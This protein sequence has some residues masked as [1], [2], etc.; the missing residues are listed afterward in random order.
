MFFLFHFNL[1]SFLSL[2]V[3]CQF[4]AGER[5]PLG[6]VCTWQFVQEFLDCKIAA[7]KKCRQ[8]AALRSPSVGRHQQW[9]AAR[10]LGLSPAG[11]AAQS[12]LSCRWPAYRRRIGRDPSRSWGP[13]RLASVIQG[14]LSGAGDHTG[15]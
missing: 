1:T 11:P 3:K 8:A 13:W 14:K 2:C 15:H 7:L 12:V 10:H 4:I 9:G 6:C 5:F